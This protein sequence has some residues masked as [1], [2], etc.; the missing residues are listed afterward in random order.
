MLAEL[1][2]IVRTIK[3]LS[4]QQTQEHP[5]IIN[6]KNNK[7]VI[8]LIIASALFHYKYRIE[9][10]SQTLRKKNLCYYS[11]TLAFISPSRY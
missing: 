5:V 9:S 10:L 7:T 4:W 3:V 2:A 8:T 1:G 11:I 6:N